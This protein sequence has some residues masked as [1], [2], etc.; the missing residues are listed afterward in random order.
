M[1]N[2]HIWAVPSEKRQ[3]AQ[4]VCLLETTEMQTGDNFYSN[5]HAAYFQKR[6]L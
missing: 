1:G 3:L 5:L 2:W 4:I 6:F